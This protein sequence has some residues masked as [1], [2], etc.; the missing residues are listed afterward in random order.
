MEATSRGVSYKPVNCQVWGM[1]MGMARMERGTII[2]DEHMKFLVRTP[3]SNI[4]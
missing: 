2:L 1:G 4:Q 3:S